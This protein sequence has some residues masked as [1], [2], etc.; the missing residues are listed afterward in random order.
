MAVSSGARPAPPPRSPLL[1]RG[2]T[3]GS[4]SGCA[5]EAAAETALPMLC[6][7]LTGR[8]EMA[9]DGI[10]REPAEPRLLAAP[11]LLPPTAASVL[12]LPTLP[13]LPPRWS[14]C[15]ACRSIRR[16]TRRP[17]P[18]VISKLTSTAG[19]GFFS[20]LPVARTACPNLSR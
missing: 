15:R 12:L 19:S 5:T 17:G 14:C 8:C 18:A 13:A 1:R 2:P 11:A 10:D 4:G 16:P 9:A 7:E 3:P 6:R 20:P